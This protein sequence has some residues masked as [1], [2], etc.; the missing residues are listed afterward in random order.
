MLGFSFSFDNGV[1]KWDFEMMALC[2]NYLSTFS[3]V[4]GM[5]LRMAMSTTL[6]QTCFY[7]VF[8]TD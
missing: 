6:V 1:F 8:S 5:F 3:H 2:F 4:G 7:T